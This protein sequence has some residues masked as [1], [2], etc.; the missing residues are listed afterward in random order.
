MLNYFTSLI[1]KYNVDNG[2][3]NK[4]IYVPESSSEVELEDIEIELD[5]IRVFIFD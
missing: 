3:E 4:F 2:D 5:K 1:E